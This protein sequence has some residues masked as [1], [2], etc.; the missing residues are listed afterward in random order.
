MPSP[1]L[2]MA[3]EFAGHRLRSPSSSEGPANSRTPLSYRTLQS[4][5]AETADPIQ[6][7]RADNCVLVAASRRVQLLGYPGV[8]TLVAPVP[9]Q[10][11]RVLQNPYRTLASLQCG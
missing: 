9:L 1:R 2:M 4:R 10:A 11:R 5:N 3:A 8:R 7:H 6:E